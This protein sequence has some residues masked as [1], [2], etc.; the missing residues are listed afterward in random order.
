M[1]NMTYSEIKNILSGISDPVEKLEMVMDIGRGL[2]CP[3]NGSECTE[4][5]GCA[6]FVQICQKD[7]R[8]YGVADSALVRGIVAI[9]VAMAN[10][11]GIEKIKN[12]NLHAEFSGLDIN[13]GAGRLNGLDS[14]IRFFQNL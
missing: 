5:S 3:P 13:L 6:S 4:I 11:F 12:M 8:F 9:L 2:E 14:M 1:I 10:E 7:G